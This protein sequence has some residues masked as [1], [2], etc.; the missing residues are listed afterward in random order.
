MTDYNDG[1]YRGPDED[2]EEIDYAGELARDDWSLVRSSWHGREDDPLAG[3][4]LEEDPVARLLLD[5]VAIWHGDRSRFFVPSSHDL[6]PW[7]TP[8]AEILELLGKGKSEDLRRAGG[9]PVSVEEIEARLQ[10]VI[11]AL[12]AAPRRFWDPTRSALTWRRHVY[13]RKSP[14]TYGE[15]ILRAERWQ[16]SFTRGELYAFV[17]VNP[18]DRR[19]PRQAIDRAVYRHVGFPDG[20][21][22]AIEDEDNIYDRF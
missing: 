5:N 22:P 16:N 11:P 7:V 18:S 6:T 8:A 19:E 4:G 9:C 14:K 12:M 13:D 20:F 21:E 1:D 10:L 2:R 3:V 15:A 17:A